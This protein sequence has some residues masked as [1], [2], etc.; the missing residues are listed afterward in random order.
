MKKLSYLFMIVLSLFILT[1]CLQDDEEVIL[2]EERFEE[3]IQLWRDYNFEDMY[4]MLSEETKATYSKADF[5]DRYEK[6]IK[7]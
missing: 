1:A 6:S 3:Y 2:P 4:A 5:I 7:T